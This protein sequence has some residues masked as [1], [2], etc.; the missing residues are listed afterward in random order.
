MPHSYL[1]FDVE[2]SVHSV[3]AKELGTLKD[4]CASWIEQQLGVRARAFATLGLKAGSRFMLHVWAGE[5]ADIQTFARDLLHTKLGGHLKLTYS[6]LGMTRAS[7][8]N[9]KGTPP[10]PFED[11]NKKYLVVYPFTKTIEWHLKPRDERASIMRDHVGVGRKYSASID[12]L[13]LYSYGVDD[14]EFVVSYE[15]DSLQEFQTL[16]ME[17]RG[18]EA[19][20]YTLNDL[21]MFT[22]VRMSPRQVLDMV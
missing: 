1:F 2:A 11:N 15:T 16:V 19:R 22:C 17:L 7:P 8:Y 12:Q 20:R 5:A 10:K 13:L 9:P 18:T 14:H 4:E 21:P 3:P 6:L